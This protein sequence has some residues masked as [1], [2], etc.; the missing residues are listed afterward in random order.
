[1]I[2][3]HLEKII[4]KKLS[5]GK[6]IIVLGAR[7]TG[8]TTL[9]KKIVAKIE[10]VLWLNADEADTI[11]LFENSSSSRFKAIF[12]KKK[13]VLKS[14]FH[15]LDLKPHRDNSRKLNGGVIICF[16]LTTRGD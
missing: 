6:V 7:Q 8:K 5:D 12:A 15:S 3:R 14:P 11:A 16:L 13:I 4:E 2:K 9:L 1:M 10:N